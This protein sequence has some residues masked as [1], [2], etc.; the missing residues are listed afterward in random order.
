MTKGRVNCKIQCAKGLAKKG[1]Q[2]F[3]A[4]I[5]GIRDHHEK[6]RIQCTKSILEHFAIQDV[7]N[8]YED[9]KTQFISL[10]YNI[11]DLI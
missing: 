4:L 11:K 10:V 5:L 9:K 7:I 6:V 8:E 2:N 1:V 3:R